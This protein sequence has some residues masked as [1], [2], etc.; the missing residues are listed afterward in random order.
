M[1]CDTFRLCPA[2]ERLPLIL[3]RLVWL[4]L[5]IALIAGSVQWLV[6]QWQ[7]IP[8]ILAAEQFEAREGGASVGHDAHAHGQDEPWMPRDGFERQ[9]WTWVADVVQAFG[10]ALTM[11]A[12]LGLWARRSDVARHPLRAGLIVA[13]AGFVSLHLWPS[14][15][16]PAEV[17]GIEAA[18]LG[19]RQA[20][21]LL[22]AICAA[23]ACGVIALGHRRLR[24]LVVAS[25]LM[26]PF[27]VG[28]PSLEGDPFPG[29]DARAITQLR[30]LQARFAWA[31]VVVSLAQ[32]L[33]LGLL[34][35]IALRR[36]LLPA[37]SRADA[38]GETPAPVGH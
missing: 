4:A 17:P 29:L 21:W 16:L 9:V 2:T 14:L 13:A 20:W 26:L 35:G 1:T 24:W 12:L 8:I 3:R 5:G 30:G 32:W 18:P 15:G 6:Q 11:L 34:C 28:A 10:I 25:L 19:A 36:S 38:A 22:A 31:T 33:V 23:A 37:I 27:V 7:A